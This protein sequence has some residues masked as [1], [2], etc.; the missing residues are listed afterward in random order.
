[1]YVHSSRLSGLNCEANLNSRYLQAALAYYAEQD[2]L[3]D[4]LEEI[5]YRVRSHSL[6][7]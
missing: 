6:Y 1:M 3:D 4:P 5:I 7:P 2:P